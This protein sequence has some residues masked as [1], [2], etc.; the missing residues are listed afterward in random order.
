MTRKRKIYIFIDALGWE[1][2]EK[3]G[4]MRSKFPFRQRVKMQFGYSSAALPTILT[5]EYP[6]RHG[7]FSFF[8]YDPKN[9]PFGIFRFVKYFFG[10]GLHPNCI[11]NRGRVR[12]IISKSVSK[13]LGFTGYFSLYSVP[14]DRLRYFDYCE[15]KDIFLPDGLAPSRNLADT[16]R[17]SGLKFHIS[18]WRKS[19]AENFSDAADALKNGADFAFVYTGAFDGFMHDNVFDETA[20][21]AK[22]ASYE[23]LLERF[24][25]ELEKSGIHSDITVISDHGMTPTKSTVDIMSAVKKTGLKFGSD[26]VSFFDS[27]MARFWYPSDSD[28]A[29]SIIRG[30]V[31]A[32]SGHFLS[33]EEKVKY[34]IN[35]EKNKYGEDIFLTDSGI[36]ISPCDLGQKAL[37]GMHGYSP[38]DADSYAC[39]LSTIEPP[40]KPEEV[41]DFFALMAC[42]IK[43]LSK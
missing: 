31:N 2:A 14:F 21:A 32:F 17:E 15:K 38:E 25:A 8:Y 10:A 35:F 18:D 24:S 33:P 22:L 16:L 40:F 11:L 36:Q 27:T 34:G 9:S 13:A 42:G 4:F 19:E 6:E 26:Y 37:N 3:H 5:G 12:R 29:R 41:K 1:I 39:L 28:S 20:I 23:T 7:H 43:E 30:A